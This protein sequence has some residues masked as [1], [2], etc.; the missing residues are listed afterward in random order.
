MTTL[1]GPNYDNLLVA[2]NDNGLIDYSFIDMTTSK[3]GNKLVQTLDSG[4]ININLLPTST[5][6]ANN[7]IPITTSN[8]VL[9]NSWLDY[10]TNTAAA[11]KVVVTGS[12]KLISNNLLNTTDG[13]TT[14]ESANASKIVKTTTNGKINDNLL[15]TTKSGGSAN[16][17]TIVKLDSNGLLDPSLFR[18]D[19]FIPLTGGEP[20][21]NI[22]VIRPGD[23]ANKTLENLK[24]K[25]PNF[26]GFG[27]SAY[28]D[29]FLIGMN[30]TSNTDNYLVIATLDDG[31]EPIYVRQYAGSQGYL[32]MPNN[33][34]NEIT[35]MD[36]NGYTSLINL[37]VNKN[38]TVTTGSLSVPNGDTNIGK[39]L[40]VG[41]NTT[42][43]NSLYVENN[44][45][46]N[47]G[48]IIVNSKTSYPSDP[49]NQTKIKEEL[50][51][52]SGFSSSAYTDGCLIGMNLDEGKVSDTD[53]YL[54]IATY[55]NG[56][57]PIVFRQYQSWNKTG[58]SKQHFKDTNISHEVV[59]MDQ[60]GNTTLNSLTVSGSTT[61]NDKLIANKGI[62]IP[63][64]GDKVVNSSNDADA[65]LIIGNKTG[66]HVSFDE[67][68]ISARSNSTG[69][70]SPLHLNPDGGS[71]IIGS[72]QASTNNAPLT[73]YGKITANNGV[74]TT[75]LT[76]SGLSQLKGK[77]VIAQSGDVTV[78]DSS[79]A[80]L[81]IGSTTG[82][83]IIIDD[84]E[85]MAKNSKNTFSN[86][87]IQ[88]GNDGA[89][90]TTAKAGTGGNT[91]F[92]GPVH[93]GGALTVYNNI[94][95]SDKTVKAGN[96]DGKWGGVIN[97]ITTHDKAPDLTR[98]MLTYVD[99]Y[100]R[101][102]T[103]SEMAD[104][105]KSAINSGIDMTSKTPIPTT[106]SGVGQVILISN[107]TFTLPNGGTWFVWFY[108]SR[109]DSD[110]QD[111]M[112]AYNPYVN[113][114]P[115]QK[116]NGKLIWPGGT[117]FN[118]LSGQNASNGFAWRIQ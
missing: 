60:S 33:K 83:A 6:G 37:S 14:T 88:M 57:E 76:A 36:K 58:D 82:S 70:S 46:V 65:P 72:N 42:V 97:Q 91:Y 39:N 71:V 34:V 102:I 87:Y 23:S 13:S 108:R 9:N 101:Y 29:G 67:N 18:N 59:L 19:Q 117:K 44:I 98:W 84:C 85:I 4:L 105:M 104:K 94:T 112:N 48:N 113:D 111:G 24:S 86:L 3:S 69:G 106:S 80:P 27:S 90:S 99:G 32:N 81:V 51:D 107:A 96:F 1:G 45:D 62:N 47:A 25:Y 41:G 12:D 64:T 114:D 115:N 30:G 103:M 8:N 2:T 73:V 26:Y 31:N 89:S 109:Y 11:N 43:N 56:N 100:I 35:L 68:E 95:A 50:P 5:T 21:G 17:N 15:K 75:T 7:K 40:T 16:A 38:L 55:D 93:I 78:S 28:T 92:G 54:L 110:Y 66:L 10:T 79:S 20:S 116:L 61:L 52:F 49:I 22:L 74:S 63:V 53:T 77:V 118:A